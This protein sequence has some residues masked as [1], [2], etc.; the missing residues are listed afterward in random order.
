MRGVV[1]SI[2]DNLFSEYLED[3]QKDKEMYD[4]INANLKYL[5]LKGVDEL[6]KYKDI[7]ID[8]YLIEEH[9]NIIR[10]FKTDE[11][12]KQKLTQYISTAYDG[13]VIMSVFNKIKLIRQIEQD[14]V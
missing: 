3:T 7:M 8:K 13:S 14:C 12:I 5:N 1:Q 4:Q 2:K 9:D 10:L 6:K 11:F